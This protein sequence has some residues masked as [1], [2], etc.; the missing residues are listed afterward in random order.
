MQVNVQKHKK[1]VVEKYS[2]YEDEIMI[3]NNS[4]GWIKL[5]EEVRAIQR[6][7]QE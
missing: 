2:F 1:K 4:K 7:T 3:K 6:D 5:V